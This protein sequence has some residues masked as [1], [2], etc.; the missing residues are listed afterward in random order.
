MFKLGVY[1][2]VRKVIGS[3][4]FFF[5]KKEKIKKG[6]GGTRTR[7]PRPQV[8]LFVLQDRAPLD[9]SLNPWP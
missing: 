9:F 7:K 2:I 3:S 4:F 1:K 8:P 6:E 5:K